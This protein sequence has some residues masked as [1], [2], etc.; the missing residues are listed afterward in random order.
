[1]MYVYMECLVYFHILL[2]HIC[3]MVRVS[4]SQKDKHQPWGYPMQIKLEFPKRP[5]LK[6]MIVKATKAP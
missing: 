1:M 2:E 3:A 4:D 6:Y 5:T